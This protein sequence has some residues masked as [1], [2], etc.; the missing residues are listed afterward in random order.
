MRWC[1]VQFSCFDA[2]S[3]FAKATLLG[4]NITV[5]RGSVARQVCINIDVEESVL[6][7]YFPRSHLE[8]CRREKKDAFNARNRRR[9]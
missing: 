9:R 6:L 4:Y 7:P 5:N 3:V 8:D 1:V 2:P